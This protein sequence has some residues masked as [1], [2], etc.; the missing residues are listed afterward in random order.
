LNKK[1]KWS[2]PKAELEPINTENHEGTL[3]LNQ[4]GTTMFFTTCQS[5]NKKELG[6]DIS[7]SQLKGKL[8]GSLN[9]LEIKV[10]SNTTLGHPT[11]SSDEK[12]VIFSADMKGG[13]GGKDYGWLLK[14]LEVSG[15]SQQI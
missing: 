6:C 12:Y 13:Y 11:I 15:V 8:W 4:N 3:C 9:K 5:E 1:G 14:W 10:D 2:N 7:I